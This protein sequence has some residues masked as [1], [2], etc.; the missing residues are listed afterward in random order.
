MRFMAM[1]V[2]CS[3]CDVDMGSP[4]ACRSMRSRPMSMSKAIAHNKEWNQQNR[5][6]PVH[7]LD[8]IRISLADE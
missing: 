7:P 1:L 2:L 3:T 4:L 6:K 8:P 5:Y